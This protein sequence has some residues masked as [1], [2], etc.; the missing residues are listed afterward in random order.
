MV[1][2]FAA[3]VMELLFNEAVRPASLLN[4]K[5][6]VIPAGTPLNVSRMLVPFANVPCRFVLTCYIA[7]GALKSHNICPH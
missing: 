3:V 5:F 4:V 2:V 7:S 1:V 6:R